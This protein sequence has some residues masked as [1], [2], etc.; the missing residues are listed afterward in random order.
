MVMTMRPLY[1]ITVSCLS[2][3]LT[4]CIVRYTDFPQPSLDRTPSPKKESVVYYHVNPAAYYAKAAGVP[5][6]VFG[7]VFIAPMAIP[8]D[9][10]PMSQGRYRELSR[11]FAESHLVAQAV[12]V[13]S[14]PDKGVYCVVDVKH[15]PPSESAANATAISLMFL[16]LLPSYSGTAMDVVR[17][18]LYVDRELQKIYRYQ[19]RQDRWMWAGLLPLLWVNFFTAGTDEAFRAVVNQFLLDAI[20]DG[21]L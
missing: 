17:F 13:P 10:P 19:V 5:S 20:R 4:G 1:T 16:G 11:A 8:I 6:T 15:K 2:F 12:P 14:P 21:Y 9:L 3:L 7:W 18:D